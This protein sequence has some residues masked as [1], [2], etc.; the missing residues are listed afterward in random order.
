METVKKGFLTIISEKDLELKLNPITID[1]LI[2]RLNEINLQAIEF[3]TESRARIMSV[4]GVEI[5]DAYE[6]FGKRVAIIGVCSTGGLLKDISIA[7]HEIRN[8]AEIISMRIDTNKT[9]HE[10]TQ[11][12]EKYVGSF[13]IE[14]KFPFED[15]AMEIVEEFKD[16]QI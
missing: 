1:N 10:A 14:D 12:I 2:G 16:H 7:M 9:I 8:Y 4:I 13:T 3:E 6:N 5:K 15:F 11:V